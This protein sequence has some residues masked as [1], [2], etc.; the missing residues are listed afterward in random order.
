MATDTCAE[1]NAA[2]ALPRSAAP[3]QVSRFRWIVLVVLGCIVMLVNADQAAFGVAL[4]SIKSEFQIANAQAGLFAG[5]M[6]FGFAAM[7]IPAG[8]A[9]ARFGP[10]A[11]MLIGL[12]VTAV[13]AFQVG[14][15]ETARDVMTYRCILGLAEASFSLCCVSIINQWFPTS[16]RGTANGLYWGASKI[17]PVIAPPLAVIVLQELGW[18]SIFKMFAIPVLIVALLWFL[19]VHNRPDQSRFG[20]LRSTGPNGTGSVSAVTIPVRREAQVPRWLDRVIRLKPVAPV[21]TISGVFRSWNL[22]GNSLAGALIVGVFYVFVAWLPSFLM[23]EKHF[24]LATAGLLS[25]V[26]FVG[27]AAGNFTGGWLSDKMLGMRR[28]PLTLF[29]PLLSSVALISLGY[30]PADEILIAAL[31]LVTGFVIGLGYAQFFVY[32]MGVTTAETYPVAFAVLNIGCISAAGLFPLL[33]GIIL[34][35]YSWTMV[36][37]LLAVAAAC[38]FLLVATIEEPT[39]AK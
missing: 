21:A 2:T 11:I 25:S 17:G 16:E 6:F 32:P 15:S 37:A 34:D 24:E 8:L 19:F 13:A 7:Q 18:R 27:T 23:T 12:V 20:K 4:P 1:A 26:L 5:M 29:G 36:F 39:P 28:K 30:A 33:T 22:M 14:A 31:L 38:S 35:S 10:R 3:M 9:V